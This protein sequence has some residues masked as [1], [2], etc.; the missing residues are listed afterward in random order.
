MIWQCGSYSFDSRTPVVMGILNLTPDSFSDG[1]SYATTRVAVV[2]AL[3]MIEEGA[4]IID[5]GGEST[6]S[7]AASVSVEEELERVIDVVRELAAQDICVSIDTRH[8]EVARACVEAGASIINDVSGFRDPEMRRLAAECSAGLVLMHMQG[9]PGTM[10]NNP[11]Y[12]DV[13]AEVKNYLADQAR[14][15]E[16]AGVARERICVDPGPGFGKTYEHTKDVIRNFQEFVHLGYPVMCAVSRKS[17]V[18]KLYKID[19]PKERDDASAH[20]AL[21]ACELG[22]SVVRTHNVA[23]TMEKLKNL[24]PYALIGLGSNL[25]LVAHDGEEREGKIALIN[26]AISELC[27]LPDTHIVDIAPF[28]ES[29]PAYFEDQDLFVNGVLLMRTG[30]PPRDLLRYLNII[31]DSLGRV[32]TKAN[33]PRTIDLDILDYQLY[34]SDDETLH[35]PHPLLHERD[36][37]VKPLLDILPHHVLAD[38]REVRLDTVKVGAAHKIESE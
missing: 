4:S 20:E 17:V 16:E 10:Q 24:R 25:A 6:R 32:R 1:G 33:G 9:E 3:K 15:L 18:G 30:L 27:F 31:E 8:P 34:V 36:F 22:C 29:E 37:V 35:L 11:Q 13:V 14:L 2:H 28:Y 5:V 23:S 38:N 26:Q 12:N 19:N 7:G 21:L